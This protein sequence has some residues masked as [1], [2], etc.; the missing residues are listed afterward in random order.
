VVRSSFVI[1]S[2]TA[3]LDR[4]NAAYSRAKLNDPMVAGIET[5]FSTVMT[6]HVRFGS[7]ADIVSC[8]DDVCFTPK[9]ERN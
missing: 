9:S 8:P 1:A 6:S 2:Q 4:H 5:F 3:W 7:K